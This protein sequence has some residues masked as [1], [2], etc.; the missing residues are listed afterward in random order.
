MRFH[1]LAE[2]RSIIHNSRIM[3]ENTLHGHSIPYSYLAESNP[4]RSSANLERKR[5]MAR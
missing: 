5:I 3:K 2:N 1:R 4:R